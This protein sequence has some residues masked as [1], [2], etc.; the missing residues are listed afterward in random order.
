LF[1]A[2]TKQRTDEA[3]W[4]HVDRLFGECRIPQD[5]PAGRREFERRLEAR[6]LAETDKP[7]EEFRAIRHGWCFSDDS[8]RKEL[9][10]QMERRAGTYHY[11]SELQEVAEEKA[12]RIVAEELGIAKWAEGQLRMLRKGHPDKIRIAHR[13]RKETTVTLQWI[14]A[15]LHMG[16][17]SHLNHLLYWNRRAELEGAESVAKAKSPKALQGKKVDLQ[18]DEKRGPSNRLASARSAPALA[19]DGKQNRADN[20]IPLTDPVGFDTRFD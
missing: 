2:E 9:L 10:G 6:R 5:T 12:N 18:S 8:F 13:L 17:R 19:Q 14:A 20:A 16:T 15:K 3:N 1:L 4:L 7:A 11:G